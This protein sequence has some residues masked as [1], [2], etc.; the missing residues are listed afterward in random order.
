MS[1]ATDTAG[2]EEEASTGVYPKRAVYRGRGGPTL[3]HG[4][5][6]PGLFGGLCCRFALPPCARGRKFSH[7][8]RCR[9]GGFG[10]SPLT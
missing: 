1:S 3:A 4:L 9:T 2:F 7:P 6:F 5:E 8:R 10:S